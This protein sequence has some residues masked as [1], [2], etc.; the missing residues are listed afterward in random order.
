M[1]RTRDAML[2][3][4]LGSAVSYPLMWLGGE[5]LPHRPREDDYEAI[6]NKGT[7]FAL[8]YHKAKGY[9]GVWFKKDAEYWQKLSRFI[10]FWET[11]LLVLLG[12]Q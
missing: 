5:R 3:L 9:W 2:E 1:G 12:V 6:S 7:G 11:F 10:I 8:R 4:L